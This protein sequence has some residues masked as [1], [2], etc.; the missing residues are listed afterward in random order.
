V[1]LVWGGGDVDARS[2][3]LVW[4]NSGV[5]GRIVVG[6]DGS[7]ASKDALS[8]AVEEAR[9]RGDTV[10]AI[11]AWTPPY[12]TAS[13]AYPTASAFPAAP[14][15]P[16]DDDV[17]DAIR[18]GAEELLAQVVSEAGAGDVTIEQ[19]LVEGPAASALI[20]AAKDAELLVVGPRGHGGFTGLLLGSVSQQLANHAPCPVVIVRAPDSE[21]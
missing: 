11:H 3:P 7:E 15:A 21:S 19:R 18:E 2:R 17:A 6:I 5:A 14:V 8:W 9:L 4:E 1:L 20:D 13:M 12:P 10:I 16:I